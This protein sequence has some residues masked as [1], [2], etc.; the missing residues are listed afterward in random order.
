MWYGVWYELCA[1]LGF[2][3]V[4]DYVKNSCWL[5]NLRARRNWNS[6]TMNF[7]AFQTQRKFRFEF[8]DC[9]NLDRNEMVSCKL[10]LFLQRYCTVCVYT[11]TWLRW[12]LVWKQAYC[13]GSRLLRYWAVIKQKYNVLV[14]RFVISV[15][16]NEWLWLLQ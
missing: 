6:R 5:H 7:S 15:S 13:I 9:L 4:V 10:Y 16:L 8:S 2:R 12:Y 3:I 14:L 1:F 11:V